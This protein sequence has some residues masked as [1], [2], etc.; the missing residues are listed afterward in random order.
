MVR[1]GYLFWA[2]PMFLLTACAPKAAPTPLVYTAEFLQGET[3]TASPAGLLFDPPVLAA[4]NAFGRSEINGID[5]NGRA[6]FVVT[7]PLSDESDALDYRLYYSDRQ[8][9]SGN[10]HS[11]HSG[12][13]RRT[14]RYYRYGR[15][16]P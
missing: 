2:V 15:Q 13:F 9:R 7:A 12:Y 5:L 4:T 14:F 8:S 3:A 11:Y 10:P 1:L 6:R 16:A